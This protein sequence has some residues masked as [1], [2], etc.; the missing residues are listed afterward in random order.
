M[1]EETLHT[2]RGIQGTLH[3]LSDEHSEPGP[4]VSF[5]LAQAIQSISRGR[6]ESRLSAAAILTAVDLQAAFENL[7]VPG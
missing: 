6:T 4:W 3:R 1:N 7:P 5:F 2:W